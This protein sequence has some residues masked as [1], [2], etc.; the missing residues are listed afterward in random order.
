MYRRDRGDQT[1][2][3][4]VLQVGLVHQLERD[5]VF[6]EAVP[7]EH[8]TAIRGVPREELS[9]LRVRISRFER[10]PTYERTK[11]T[12]PRANDS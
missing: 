11:E 8:R 9:T 4:K 5:S 12:L 2:E 7:S 3:E 10:V 6:A 1:H